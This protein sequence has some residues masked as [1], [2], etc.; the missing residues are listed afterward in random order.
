MIRATVVLFDV[1][2]VIVV[3]CVSRWNTPAEVEA[4]F[5]GDNFDG[6]CELAASDSGFTIKRPTAKAEA[7]LY[8]REAIEVESALLPIPEERGVKNPFVA[9]KMKPTM[10]TTLVTVIGLGRPEDAAPKVSFESDASRITVS[11]RHRGKSAACWIDDQAEVP[12][13]K[14]QLG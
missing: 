5:F 11:L 1:P 6:A 12:G 3:D 14:V 10:A 2:A 8:C 7:Q 4:R 13:I 9:V